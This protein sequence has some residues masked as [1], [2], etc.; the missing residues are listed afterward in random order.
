MLMFGMS[1][2]IVVGARFNKDSAMADFY[3]YIH[4]VKYTKPLSQAQPSANSSY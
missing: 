4:T 1:A 3:T 2:A